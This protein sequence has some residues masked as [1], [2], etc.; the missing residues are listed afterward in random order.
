[1]VRKLV[2][3]LALGIQKSKRRKKYLT[4]FKNENPASAKWK[5]PLPRHCEFIDNVSTGENSKTQ[6]QQ[7]VIPKLG[8]FQIKRTRSDTNERGSVDYERPAENNGN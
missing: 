7:I 1:M 5:L 6:Q 8:S 3:I 4:K 2:A